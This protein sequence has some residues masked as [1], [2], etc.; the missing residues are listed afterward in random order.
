MTFGV[1]VTSCRDVDEHTHSIEI[2]VRGVSV[3]GYHLTVD[4]PHKR[5]RFPHASKIHDLPQLFMRDLAYDVLHFYSSMLVQYS[6]AWAQ[7][8]VQ[9]QP[10]VQKVRSLHHLGQAADHESLVRHELAVIMNKDVYEIERTRL[11]SAHQEL[12]RNS[13]HVRADVHI[14]RLLDTQGMEVRPGHRRDRPTNSMSFLMTPPD[15]DEKWNMVEIPGAAFKKGLF[16]YVY[17]NRKCS[18]KKTK[19]GGGLDHVREMSLARIREGAS[20][21]DQEKDQERFIDF[22][23]NEGWLYKPMSGDGV[24]SINK[25]WDR[26]WIRGRQHRL[27]GEGGREGRG[28]G[29]AG[30]MDTRLLSPRQIGFFR[31]RS[32]NKPNQRK[33]YNTNLPRAT[34]SNTHRIEKWGHPSGL[35]AV[36][37]AYTNRLNQL[38]IMSLS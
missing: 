14:Q 36:P 33:S 4:L 24:K 37:D 15:M 19:E 25:V 23:S 29:E 2:T 11:N 17:R 20:L 38:S 28:E 12:G 16:T 21:E 5:V 31:S 13:S 34:R 7:G 10:H 30:R 32:Q 26:V 8:L 35:C 18:T 1:V 9:T 3:R 22:F 6:R 27:V